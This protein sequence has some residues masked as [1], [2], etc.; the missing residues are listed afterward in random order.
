MKPSRF[1]YYR[2]SSVAEAVTTL[3]AHDGAA[4]VLAGGQSLTPMLNMRLWRPEA[5][6]D[7]NDI[8]ALDH[9]DVDGPRTTLGALVRYSTVER[10]ALLAERLP[11]LVEMVGHIGDRQVRNRGT[12]GGALAHA[13]PTGEVLLACL[14]LDATVIVESLK[15]VRRV[16]VTELYDGSYSTVLAADEIVTAVEFDRSPA[17]HAFGEI[18][19]KH[20]DFAIVSVAVCGELASDGTWHDVRV[21]L[22]G[23]ADTAL[24]L[25]AA[26]ALLSGSTLADEDIAAAAALA[27]GVIDP[28]DDIRA[29]ADYRRHLTP[30]QIERVLRDLRRR[31]ADTPID[32]TRAGEQ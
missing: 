1:A 22:G 30:I 17:H 18:C 10:S 11:L 24:R 31:A 3:Q 16:P 25:S 13:D 27:L 32:I 29:S 20:H 14:T 21:G 2:P 7:I 9:I 8:D 4:R 6:I 28:P 23:V 26:E 19:R 12:V 5:L 15:G